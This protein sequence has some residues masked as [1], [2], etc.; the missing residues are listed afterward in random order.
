VPCR[1]LDLRPWLTIGNGVPDSAIAEAAVVFADSMTDL[2]WDADSTGEINAIVVALV[3]YEGPVRRIALNY[4]ARGSQ[5]PVTIGGAVI[6]GLPSD[7][8]HVTD[9]TLAL[10]MPY[11]V[12]LPPTALVE[13][14]T[15]QLHLH[16]EARLRLWPD[17][18]E[19]VSGPRTLH[20]DTEVHSCGSLACIV[21]SPIYRLDP[22]QRAAGEAVYIS[23]RYDRG[24]LLEAVRPFNAEVDGSST[25]I[26][27][28]RWLM[29]TPEG[30][31]VTFA[32]S[33]TKG[34]ESRSLLLSWHGRLAEIQI[35]SHEK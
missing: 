6:V 4:S 20:I 24:V 29:A 17:T 14:E 25:P 32:L 19:V 7:S 9:R 35:P 2:Y 18:V 22:H 15:G 16:P 21:A 5:R 12:G 23:P 33:S 11:V 3:G 27:R 26:A 13:D 28:A 10:A 31:D 1:A 8:S 30:G 34:G